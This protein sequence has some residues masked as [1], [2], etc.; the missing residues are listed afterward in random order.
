MLG[1]I[2][3]EGAI[4]E[5]EITMGSDPE[6]FVKRGGV[7]TSAF[8]LTSGTKDKPEDVGDGYFLSLDNIMLE[9][10]IPPASSKDEFVANMDKLVAIM[11]ARAKRARME[12]FPEDVAYPDER[13]LR[14]PD[15]LIFGCSSYMDAWADGEQEAEDMGEQPF[16]VAG[17]HIHIGYKNPSVIMN[18]A[19]AKAFDIFATAPAHKI[20]VAK[21][22]MD[23]YGG[24]GNYRCKADMYGLE[25]RAL[26][27]FM[28]Q[29]DYFAWMYDA[30]VK[31]VAFAHKH[32]DQLMGLTF[33]E[34]LE[35]SETLNK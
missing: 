21:E 2:N 24:F 5:F 8:R 12:L 27:G 20:H 16:R 22:R 3:V 32:F 4:E 17:C 6:I 33:E 35:L 29:H 11:D 18:K 25:C 15:A 7:P 30:T 14:R 31:A 26:G 23:Y 19:I 34:A 10:N 1:S 28:F 9:G 13:S